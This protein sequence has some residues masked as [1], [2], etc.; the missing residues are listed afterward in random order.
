MVNC[1][2][3]THQKQKSVKGEYGY[4]TFSI[5]IK[6]EYVAKLDEISE[7]TNRSRNELINLFIKYAIDN[8]KIE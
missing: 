1:E 6:E 8:C 4:R 5:R 7:S 3:K 2:R